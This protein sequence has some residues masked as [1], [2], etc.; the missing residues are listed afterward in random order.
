MYN[1]TVYKKIILYY[2]VRLGAVEHNESYIILFHTTGM[3]QLKII[4]YCS[5][6]SLP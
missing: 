3:L 6:Y 4:L 5:G 2:D 1:R